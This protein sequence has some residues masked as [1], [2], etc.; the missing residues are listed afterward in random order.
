[1][2]SLHGTETSINFLDRIQTK[3]TATHLNTVQDSNAT[4]CSLSI[5]ADFQEAPYDINFNKLSKLSLDTNTT[6]FRVYMLVWKRFRNKLICIQ[7]DKR[8]PTC[9]TCK[10]IWK[11]SVII[12]LG[13]IIIGIMK[14]SRSSVNCVSWRVQMVAWT[15]AHPSVTA[16]NLCVSL[17]SSQALRIAF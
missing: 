13:S 6:S 11:A 10:N 17:H 16:L 7:F 14:S 15:H 2:Y 9:H 4:T 1:M 3:T 12:L 5:N 8:L